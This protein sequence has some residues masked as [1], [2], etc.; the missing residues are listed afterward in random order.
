LGDEALVAEANGQQNES[1]EASAAED[2]GSTPT[3]VTPLG[4]SFTPSPSAI[5]QLTDPRVVALRESVTNLMV[6]KAFKRNDTWKKIEQFN[7]DA[8][9][10]LNKQTLDFYFKKFADDAEKKLAEDRRKARRFDGA[11]DHAVASPADYA[12]DVLARDFSAE[13]ADQIKYTAKRGV[14]NIWN[15]V[16][17]KPD[18]TLEIVAKVREFAEEKARK[19]LRDFPDDSYA[20]ILA[21]QL[22]SRAKISA[23]EALARSDARHRA[24]TGLWDQNRWILATPGGVV[25]LRTGKLRAARPEDFV[26]K[27]ARATPAIEGAEHPIWSAYLDSITRGDKELQAYLQRLAG[28]F[29][30]GDVSEQS[31]FF[32]FGDGGNGKGVFKETM[33]EILGD[34]ATVVPVSA[35]MK[36]K[37]DRHPT[38][39]AKLAGARLAVASETESGHE[40]NEQRIKELT[41]GDQLTGRFMRQDFFDFYPMHKLL[42]IGNSQPR[43]GRV[44]NAE[45]RRFHMIPFTAVIASP[46]KQLQEKLRREYSAILR[47]M[48]DG[49]LSW[50]ELGLNP[51]QGVL[52]STV[53]YFDDQDDVG[54]WIEERAI[55]RA[56]LEATNMRL[57]QDYLAWSSASSE[58]PKGKDDFLAHLR[59]LPGIERVRIGKKRD[60]G[61][62]GIGLRPPVPERDDITQG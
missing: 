4:S 61:L 1:N 40:W 60:R 44:G 51:P 35:L 28:Y 12:D 55:L 43:L 58:T 18:T 5:L 20:S 33:V 37:R 38:D 42:I 45:R 59:N 10:P 23:I 14:W 54:R 17:W 8:S 52:A 47:W 30:T 32:A 16:Y 29:L 36:A 15:G 21:A 31:L 3:V 2:R 57:Y 39:I 34:H 9:D 19:L 24:E 41:G 46:D 56:G 49:T 6:G 13:H 27:L 7:N 53:D 62:G 50:A 25:D 22:R 11:N 48:I 26:T